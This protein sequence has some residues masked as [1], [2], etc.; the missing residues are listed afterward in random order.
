MLDQAAAR[1]AAAAVR[2]AS[3]L[4]RPPLGL[5]AA[6]LAWKAARSAS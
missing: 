4:G 2:R 5:R 3:L 6:S 1:T